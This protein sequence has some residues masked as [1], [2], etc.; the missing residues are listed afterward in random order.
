MLTDLYFNIK[1]SDIDQSVINDILAKAK[2]NYIIWTT[3]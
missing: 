3:T 2:A 1:K